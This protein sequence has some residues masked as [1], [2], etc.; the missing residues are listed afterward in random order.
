VSVSDVHVTSSARRWILYDGALAAKSWLSIRQAT[1][2][3]IV[4]AFCAA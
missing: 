3:A 1:H 2:G 4:D